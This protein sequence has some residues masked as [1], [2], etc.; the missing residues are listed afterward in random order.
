MTPP[1]QKYADGWRFVFR[2]EVVI[3]G[4]V[5]DKLYT[6]DASFKF[7]NLEV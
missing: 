1:G 2:I 5:V 4:E 6:V 7:G 3:D